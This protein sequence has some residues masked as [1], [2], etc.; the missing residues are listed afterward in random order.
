MKTSLVTLIRGTA[1]RSPA[2]LAI[3]F[4]ATRLAAA[5]FTVH[6][7]GTF[8]SVSGSDGR[9]L[10]GLEVEEAALPNFVGSFAGF[11]PANKG[12]DRPVR[13]VT[14]KM[15]TP[16]L[17]FYSAAPLTVRV[18]VAFHGGSISQWYPERTGGEQPLPLFPVKD[19]RD[20]PA[21]DFGKGHEGRATW[22]V[23][24]LAPDTKQAITA[25]HDWETAQWPRARI[26]AANRVRGPKGEVEG[27]IF[28][29]GLGHFAVPLTVIAA[30]DGALTLSNTG[31]DA[32]PFV[33]VYDCASDATV[34]SW[35]GGLAPGETRSV[36]QLTAGPAPFRTALMGRG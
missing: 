30:R 20:V 11:A 6:E 29:R 23:D 19:V 33:W 12:W 9:M 3:L 2:F 1:A 21:I 22:Q 36:G 31:R 25:P 17:Y 35:S 7:W 4:F 26:A 8:T 14:V 24:V 16:V 27:F 5:D 18:D 28:Y 10:P 34:R 15:E 13:G 32:L